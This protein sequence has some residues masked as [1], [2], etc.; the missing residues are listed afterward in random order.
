[1]GLR[2]EQSHRTGFGD[3]FD[4]TCQMI[5]GLVYARV[6]Q[7]FRFLLLGDFR[8]RRGV[9]R[10]LSE[11]PLHATGHVFQK[12]GINPGRFVM[13]QVRDEDSAVTVI[14]DP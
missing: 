11:N 4:W 13:S 7:R 9:T 10:F 5:K 6:F 1:M 2:A 12:P 14:L 3:P 8:I